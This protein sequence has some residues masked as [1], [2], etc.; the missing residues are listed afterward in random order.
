[1]AQG[2]CSK[3]LPSD[4]AKNQQLHFLGI[5][6]FDQKSIRTMKAGSIV[7]RRVW[8]AKATSMAPP[9]GESSEH[10]SDPAEQT[11][12]AEFKRKRIL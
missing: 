7:P 2:G 11:R 4:D 1:M 10:F 12:I 9:V 6:K 5:T 3:D 8:S